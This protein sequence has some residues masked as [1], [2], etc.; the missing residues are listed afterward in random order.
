MGRK[1]GNHFSVGDRVVYPGYGVGEVSSIEEKNLGGRKQHFLV[2]AFTDT[3]NVS[4][5]MIPHTSIEEIGL[6]LPSSPKIV[7]H[8]FDFL[9]NGVPEAFTT[10]KDRFT[11]HTTMVAKGDLISIAKVLK[12]LYVQN[13]RK[14]LSFR[15]KK[16]Y[17]RCILL[18]SSET[19]LVK[20]LTREKME[21]AMM[22]A[23]DGNP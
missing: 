20:K 6:R 19:A 18:M 21:A 14:P 23:L 17:Q 2:L 15:E 9:K 8:A 13:K 12:A 10:W 1:S 4:R 5:V 16:M 22:A 3:E 11:A 7:G